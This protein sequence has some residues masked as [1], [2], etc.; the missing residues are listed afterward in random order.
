MG[1]FRHKKE[2]KKVGPVKRFLAVAAG[3]L[4]LYRAVKNRNL[5]KTLGAGFLIYKGVRG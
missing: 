1:L 2:T 5:R 3:T 4:R